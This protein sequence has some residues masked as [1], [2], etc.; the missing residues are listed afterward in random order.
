[1]EFYVIT[2]LHALKARLEEK[3][4]G[5]LRSFQFCTDD[6]VTVIDIV[7]TITIQGQLNGSAYVIRLL[8]K[9]LRGNF[10]VEV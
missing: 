5:I 8:M 10:S 2:F 4:A 1:V 7:T 3:I 6:I 9:K